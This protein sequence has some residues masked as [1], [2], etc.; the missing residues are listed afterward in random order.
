MLSQGKYIYCI[1]DNKHDKDF[2][3]IGIGN[4]G[5]RV[6]SI[7]FEEISAVVS[8]SPIVKYSIS[9]ENTVIHMKVM[10]MAMNDSPI[11][12]VKFGTVAPGSKIRSPEETVKLE[13]LKARYKELKDLLS[14]MKNKIELGLKAIWMNMETI[15]QEIVDKNRE[16]KILKNKIASRNSPQPY[17]HRIYLGEMVKKALDV[18]RTKEEAEILIQFIGVYDEIRCNKIF[19]DQMITNSSFLV[20]KTRIEEFDRLVEKLESTHN[21]R[22]KFKYVGPVP[23]CNFIELVIK[24]KGEECEEKT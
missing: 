18:K 2:G 15:F 23:P 13:I 9:R 22:T 21:G 8:D 7:V 6:H 10:E 17:G 19:G 1:T 11:L 14:Q 24:L 16:I 4:K 12:P 20:N 3:P 5:N